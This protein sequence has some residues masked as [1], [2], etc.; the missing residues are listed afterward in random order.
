MALARPS[1]AAMAF[2]R[3]DSLLEHRVGGIADAGIDVAEGLQPEQRR[4]MID[5]LEH[6]RGGLVNRRRAC[7]G[8]RVGLGAGMDCERGEAGDAVGH[9]QSS[10]VPGPAGPR[11]VNGG[12]DRLVV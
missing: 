7:A 1:F 12:W 4:R 9:R 2:E 5:V 3:G 11:N 8:G 10:M 6:E